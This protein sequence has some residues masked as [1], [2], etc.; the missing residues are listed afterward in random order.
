MKAKRPTATLFLLVG[1]TMFSTAQTTTPKPPT[2]A[3]EALKK[4]ETVKTIKDFFIDNLRKAADKADKEYDGTNG[5]RDMLTD[6]LRDQA[7]FSEKNHGYAFFD[8]DFNAK[9][10][11]DL[12]DKN[13]ASVKKVRSALLTEILPQIRNFPTDKKVAAEFTAIMTASLDDSIR[14][15]AAQMGIV[16]TAKDPAK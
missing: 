14:A 3:K 11:K 10:E 6:I 5:Q 2:E 15:K 13:S 1:A 16:N 8:K 9:L 7:D 12:I 4:I